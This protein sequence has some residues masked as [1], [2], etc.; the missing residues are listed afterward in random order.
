VRA[1]CRTEIIGR[2]EGVHLLREFRNDRIWVVLLRI[3]NADLM[4]VGWLVRG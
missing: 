3:R 1:C 4:L 2:E